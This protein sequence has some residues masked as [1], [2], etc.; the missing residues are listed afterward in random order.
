MNFRTLT[1]QACSALRMLRRTDLGRAVVL[2]C[3]GARAHVLTATRLHATR[4]CMPASTSWTAAVFL[5]LGAFVG[6]GVVPPSD[7]EHEAAARRNVL[8][9][10]QFDLGCSEANVVKLGDVG[11]LNSLMTRTSY[12]VT[13]AD[14]KA[15]YLA[16]C[17]SN[18]GTVS[19]TVEMNTVG[20]QGR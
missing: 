17:T 3:A 5:A 9:R 18:W 6:C 8:E 14:K 12:G 10:I 15:S 2:A 16:T 19:C 4:A 13:C 20:R 7:A 1:I 11:H